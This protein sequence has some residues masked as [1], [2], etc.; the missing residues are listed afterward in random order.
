VSAEVSAA[1]LWP[2]DGLEAIHLASLRLLQRAGV[3]VE[4]ERARAA[5]SEAGCTPGPQGRLLIPAGLVEAALAACPPRF[6]LAARATG[7]SLPIDS[8]PGPTFTHNLGGAREV[9]DPLTGVGRRA[10]LRDQI[11]L[12]RVMHHLKNQHTLCSL[13]QPGDVPDLL[14]PLY[15]YLAVAHET[16]KYIGGPGVS[17]AFQARYLREMALVTVGASPVDATGR[18]GSAVHGSSGLGSGDVCPL[19]LAF[20]PVS[21]LVLGGDVADALLETAA[22]GQVAV[23]I[24]PCPAAGTT[25]PA[26]LSAAIAQQNAEVLAGVVLLQTVAPGTPVYYGPR[27]SAVDP[28]TGRVAS[29]T[30]ETGFTAVAAVQLA[31]RYGLAC[32]CYGPS[33]DSKVA[34]A[35]LGWEHAFNAYLGLLAQPR[36]LSGIGEIQAGAATALEVLVLDDEILNDAFYALA[37]HSCDEAALD[38]E[39]MV[40]GVLSESGFLG[41]RHTRR[42]LRS[43]LCAPI[44]SFRGGLEEWTASGRRSVVDAARARVDEL[45]AREPVGLPDGVGEKLCSLIDAAAR[46]AGLDDWPD[47]RGVLEGLQA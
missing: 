47:P 4:S 41:T 2:E 42:Y 14:E 5:L 33:T 31:R 39:A 38:V 28:R 12:A 18:V 35:Q 36:F 15:S 13:V 40:E 11:E 19:D 37:A 45:L 10:T 46:E 22:M 44:I 26:T 27:L 6:T 34:D 17:F 3:R 1:G 30:P 20:S 8:A 23:E 32:D 24:L 7:H 16:D 29:G 43:E 21:P 25:A 9:I